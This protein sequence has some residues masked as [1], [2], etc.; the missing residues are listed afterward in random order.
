M[1]SRSWSS[2]TRVA[3]VGGAPTDLRTYG[4]LVKHESASRKLPHPFGGVRETFSCQEALAWLLGTGLGCGSNGG[5]SVASPADSPRRRPPA[6]C[7]C[8]CVCDG[9]MDV[10]I[11][12]QSEQRSPSLPPNEYCTLEKAV[13]VDI[14]YASN[15]RYRSNGVLTCS[16]I[17][18]GWTQN[19]HRTAGG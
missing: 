8:G 19:T 18:H 17:A 16:G 10:R 15:H 5:T 13:P 3:G 14:L 6:A 1:R 4:A 2:S 9:M 12:N 11:I 7:V